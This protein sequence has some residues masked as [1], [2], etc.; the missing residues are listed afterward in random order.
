MGKAFEESFYKRRRFCSSPPY[1]Y[2]RAAGG[3]SRVSKAVIGRFLPFQNGRYW[4]VAAF[5]EGQ[6]W[7]DSCRP[8]VAAY[9]PGCVKTPAIVQP[10]DRRDRGGDDHEAIH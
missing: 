5:R 10:F 3:Q 4:P 6:L 7:V 8:R 2:N 1:S 9:D